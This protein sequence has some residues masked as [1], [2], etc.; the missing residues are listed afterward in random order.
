MTADTKYPRAVDTDELSAVIGPR[1]Y[2]AAKVLWNAAQDN[3]GDLCPWDED[4]RRRDF[5][6][7]LANTLEDVLEVLEQS[8][9]RAADASWLTAG[10][11]TGGTR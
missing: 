7:G 5:L 1:L 2:M 6:T 11:E 10:A 8:H 4:A 9:A 3:I